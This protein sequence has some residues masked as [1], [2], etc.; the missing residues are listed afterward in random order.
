MK[1]ERKI[2]EE[3]KT[4]HVHRFVRFNTMKMVILLKA[5]YISNT[6]SFKIPVQGQAFNY[7]TPASKAGRSLEL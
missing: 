5:I 1:T 2:P 4:S 6:I 3:R 7:S